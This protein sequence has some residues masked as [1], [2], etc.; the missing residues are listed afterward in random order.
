M[1]EPIHSADVCQGALGSLPELLAEVAFERKVY[2]VADHNTYAAA[3][4]RANELLLACGFDVVCV[5]LG[6]G[7]VPDTG[8]FFTLLEQIDR[9]GYLLACGSG[10]INDLVRYAAFK[11]DKPYSI[12][13]TA[14]SMDGYASHV[15]PLTVQ[16]VKKTYNAVTPQI[17]IADTNILSAAP[18]GMIQAG[19]GD[20]IGKITSLLDWRLSNILCDEVVEE[21]SFAMVKEE[22][23]AVLKLTDDLLTRSP[24]SIAALMRG[25]IGSGVAMQLAG[26]SRPA[27]GSEHHISHFLEL[28]GDMY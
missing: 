3:G 11:L 21:R 19:Y 28:Y 16:G 10:T 4:R 18:W 27:S 12:I 24:E 22:L 23:T 25:L 20:L 1:N 14:P 2:L 8:Y 7:V 6:D 13:A 26:S 5:L 17:I 9:N 15:S